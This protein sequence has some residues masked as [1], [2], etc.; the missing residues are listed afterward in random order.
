MIPGKAISTSLMFAPFQ[1]PDSIPVYN[2]T[3]YQQGGIG[4]ADASQGLQ[5]QAWYLSL[6]GNP[7]S[8]NVVLSA[9]NTQ[10]TILFSAPNI[11][12]ISLSFDQNMK[13]AVAY[14][15][16]GN[17]KFWWYDTTIPGY[18]IIDLAAGVTSPRC[19]LDDKRGVD[20]S[21][22]YSDIILAY[23]YNHNLC[24]RQERDRFTVEYVL[25]TNID[26]LISNPT[27][28]KIGMNTIER[29]QFQIFGNL[30]Q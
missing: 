2:T 9:P 8:N 3:D 26:L 7:S 30:Y 24:F 11:T 21:L 29:L 10:P 1:Y 15:S 20:I 28:N 4:I 5:V 16:Q 25:Q 22:G 18:T 14:V 27:L 6:S 13:P 19:T 23:I 12:E 17:P